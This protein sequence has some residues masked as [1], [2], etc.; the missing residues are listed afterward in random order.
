MKP[1][2]DGV[3][4]HEGVVLE[5]KVF[6]FVHAL[7]AEDSDVTVSNRPQ[8]VRLFT[9]TIFLVGKGRGSEGRRGKGNTNHGP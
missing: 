5:E 4:D 7:G 9:S 8:Q 1:P 3:R 6:V 2:Q